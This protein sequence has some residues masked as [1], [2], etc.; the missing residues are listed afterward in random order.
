MKIQG[1]QNRGMQEETRKKQTPGARLCREGLVVKQ[2][3]WGPIQDDQIPNRGFFLPPS[4]GLLHVIAVIADNPMKTRRHLYII[5]TCVQEMTHGLLSPAGMGPASNM[6]TVGLSWEE[7]M[8]V[9]FEHPA[10]SPL[11]FCSSP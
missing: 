4:M 11:T 3:T 7:E 6:K 9:F 5:K 8:S 1:E 2:R 10:G